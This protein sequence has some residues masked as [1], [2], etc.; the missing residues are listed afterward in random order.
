MASKLEMSV[1]DVDVKYPQ[2]RSD[3]LKFEK[4]VI[5]ESLQWRVDNPTAKNLSVRKKSIKTYFPYLDDE[6]VRTVQATFRAKFYDHKDDTDYSKYWN[7]PALSQVFSSIEK[8]SN[9][10]TR[11]LFDIDTP[12][13]FVARQGFVP[14]KILNNIE[15]H[16]DELVY[17]GKLKSEDH[18]YVIIDAVRNY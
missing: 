8:T 3:R 6:A 15:V 10:I 7:E 18:F 2:F 5:L 4:R 12:N 9:A 17:R 16:F 13:G 1:S 11:A 14:A